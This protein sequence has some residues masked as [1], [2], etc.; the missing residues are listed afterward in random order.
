MN[1][2]LSESL[3]FKFKIRGKET[4]ILSDEISLVVE[5]YVGVGTGDTNVAGETGGM[6]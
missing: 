4:G 5:P 1:A 2:N 3:T 6:L